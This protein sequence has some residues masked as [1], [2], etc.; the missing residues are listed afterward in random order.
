MGGNLILSKW[1]A[2]P[3]Q[4]PDTVQC[5]ERVMAVKLYTPS[6]RPLLLVNV[7]LKSG[8]RTVAGHCLNSVF[9]WLAETGEE[10]VILGDFNLEISNWPIS[11]AQ[12]CGRWR[13]C[14]EI[15]LGDN[16]GEGTFRNADGKYS[17]R[18]IDFG[19]VTPH[20]HVCERFQFLGVADHDGVAYDFHINDGAA[21][22]WK[23]PP[24]AALSER[25]ISSFSWDKQW[26]LVQHDF[27][28]AVSEGDLDAAWVCLSNCAESLLSTS[29]SVGRAKRVGPQQVSSPPSTK[30]PDFQTLRER[31]LRRFGRR[32]HEYQRSGLPEL[33]PKLLRTAGELDTGLLKFA[34]DDPALLS[35][36]LQ[37]ADIEAHRA[38][39]HQ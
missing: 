11:S 32:V 39:R 24:C 16:L 28:T 13:A 33:R 38:S 34:L 6:Q 14:D 12:A 23:L 18:N 8:I 26:I 36:T 10:A 31:K 17:G 4:V 30:A 9:T 29:G 15:I 1:P 19:L 20:V 35:A 5:P 7:Y 21:K 27:A 3:V 25:P 22:P 37:L 2:Q